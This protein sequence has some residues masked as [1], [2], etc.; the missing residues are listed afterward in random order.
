MA[1]RRLLSICTARQIWGSRMAGL[2]GA[3]QV[4]RGCQH[5]AVTLLPPN[6]N[7]C[8]S[9]PCAWLSSW[10]CPG[11]RCLPSPP[12]D[13]ETPQHHGTAQSVPAWAEQRQHGHTAPSWCQPGAQPAACDGSAPAPSVALFSAATVAWGAGWDGQRPSAV[14][15]GLVVVWG[16]L[17]VVSS[18]PWC[19]CMGAVGTATTHEP[20][21]LCSTGLCLCGCTRRAAPN[22][23][24][25][26]QVPRSHLC[27]ASLLISYGAAFQGSPKH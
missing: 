22:A 25:P 26:L 3:G 23:P 17:V 8:G 2:L 5:C 24:R 7:R 15:G 19:H 16:G 27:F 9:T 21:L 14:W 11:S 1:A 20:K 18:S 12:I 10:L 6:Q 4:G 13:W